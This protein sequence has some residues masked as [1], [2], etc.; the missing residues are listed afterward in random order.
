MRTS[1][2]RTSAEQTSNWRTS[3]RR[4]YAEQTSA[5]RTLVRR[6]FAPQNSRHWSFEVQP[7]ARRIIEGELTKTQ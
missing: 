2:R 5:M 6:S 7:N 4:T 1:P 3:A